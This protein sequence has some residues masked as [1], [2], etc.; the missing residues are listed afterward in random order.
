MSDL[1][2]MFL[3]Q[4]SSLKNIMVVFMSEETPEKQ[5]FFYSPRK[6]DESY[7]IHFS[8]IYYKVSLLL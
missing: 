4:N 5:V 6:K 2:P 1:S 7:I 8:D 3:L